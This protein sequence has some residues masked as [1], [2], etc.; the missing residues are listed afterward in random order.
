MYI[1]GVLKE[2]KFAANL[3]TEK[4]QIVQMEEWTS[5]SLSCEDA[6][7]ILQGKLNFVFK[8]DDICF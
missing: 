8:L 5:D 6:K 2:G 1:A 4:T 3:I 7:R